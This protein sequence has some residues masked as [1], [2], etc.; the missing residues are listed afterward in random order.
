MDTERSLTNDEALTALVLWE[1]VLQLSFER[2]AG[3]STPWRAY[4]ETVG[5]WEMRQ[6]MVDLTPLCEK[7]WRAMDGETH[8]TISF[9]WEFVPAWIEHSIDWTQ[10]PPRP[11]VCL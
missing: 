10:D 3:T 1:A 6:L 8:D 2:G 4:W 7:A 11:F 9:D 5:T